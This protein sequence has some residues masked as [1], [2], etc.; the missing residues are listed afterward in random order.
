MRRVFL[1]ILIMVFVISFVSCDSEEAAKKPIVAVGIV[2]QAAFVDKVAGGMVDVVTLIPPGNSPANY[3]PT[4]REMQAL[5]EAVIY[6]TLRMPTEEAN[7]LPK[8]PGFNKNLKIVD[9]HEAVGELY[10]FIYGSDHSLDD[11][12]DES[13]HEDIKADP[14]L[15]LSPKRAIVMVERIAGELSLLDKENES[16]YKK[17]AEEYIEELKNLDKE[18]SNLF[19]QQ[20]DKEFIIYHGSYSYFADDYGL[21]MTSIEIDGK[22]A[23]ATEIRKVIESARENDIKAIFYQDEFDDNQ[24]RTVA[25]EIDGVVMKASPLSYDYIGSLRDFA[26]TVA[27]LE[28][29]HE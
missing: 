23:T 27:G 13:E 2:P 29:Q 11:G 10:P 4:A 6:F 17:N 12:H 1:V 20:V 19:L 8:A 16:V 25:E 9:L 15:W 7:I 26:Y 22:Q 24:A 21:T 18:L 14:H 3:Q 28:K 5:S